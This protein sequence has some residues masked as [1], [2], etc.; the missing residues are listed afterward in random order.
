MIPSGLVQSQDNQ[1]QTRTEILIE[2]WYVAQA[3]STP[4]SM[5]VVSS[6]HIAH[7]MKLFNPPTY[8]TLVLVHNLC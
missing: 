5:W 2:V 3:I 7:R 6:L 8:A 1:V 4:V